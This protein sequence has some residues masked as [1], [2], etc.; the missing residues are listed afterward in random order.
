MS[1]RRKGRTK[2]LSIQ[3]GPRALGSLPHPKHRMGSFVDL[4]FPSGWGL[5]DVRGPISKHGIPETGPYFFLVWVQK[6]L[7]LENTK[8]IFKTN[9]STKNVCFSSVVFKMDRFKCTLFSTIER[10]FR[11][12]KLRAKGPS[13]GSL[14]YSLPVLCPSCISL[15][16]ELEPRASG[17]QCTLFKP[18]FDDY[19]CTPMIPV[20]QLYT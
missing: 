5:W 8:I 3:G 2:T 6:I 20:P 19:I 14:D 17:P 10:T 1:T 9:A 15:E 16:T 13:F 18:E 4:L 7:N 12:S 11:K